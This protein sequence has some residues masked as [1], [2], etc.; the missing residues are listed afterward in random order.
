MWARKKQFALLLAVTGILG[1]SSAERSYQRAVTSMIPIPQTKPPAINL[2]P[3]TI[4]TSLANLP[5]DDVID[6][7]I[8]QE[9]RPS[10]TATEVKPTISTPSLD[11]KRERP[12]GREKT[13][14][15]ANPSPATQA[16]RDLSADNR[17][18]ELLEK[19]LDKAVEQPKERRRLQF[20]K[21]VVDNPKVRHFVKYYSTTAKNSF[22][23]LLARS[24]KYMPMIAKVLNQEGL[25][26]ELGYLALLESQFIVNTTSRN[27]AVGL[28]Q[29][30]ATTA[31]KYGLRI[32]EWVDE[33]RDP[34]K[35]TRAAAAYL[36][37]LHEYYGRWYLATAAYNA[38]PGTI[39]KALQQSRAKDFWSI[40]GNAQLREETR[41]FVPKFV[42][43]SLIATDPKKY[44]F[45]DVRY[46]PPLSYEEVELQAPMK[47]AALAEV[48]ETEEFMLRALNPALLRNSTAPG[49]IG[50]RVNLPTGK[51]AIYLAKANEKTLEK[52]AEPVQVVTHE[53]KKGETLFSIARRYGLTVRRLMEFN[54]LT[55]SQLST[56]QKLR[57]LLEG[58][59]GKLR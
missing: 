41:N 48:A 2:S 24:G 11:Q 36:K 4:D 56:G 44:G 57:I 58:L 5:A 45:E 46:E 59:R 15:S 38:G 47:F 25:P 40:K 21:E 54:G 20:S 34:F 27:G 7:P 23:E 16:P 13:A 33:R 29:F 50:F 3:A 18:L 37:D 26:E 12:D 30:I 28:W 17:L 55:T 49:E 9:K 6:Q 43:I 53:V 1:C 10:A 8:I 52:E 35:S 39:D 32:D 31:R 22:Q 42:A 14:Q 19:D 51:A